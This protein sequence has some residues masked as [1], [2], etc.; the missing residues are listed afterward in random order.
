MGVPSPSKGALRAIVLNDF[1]FSVEVAAQDHS[2]DVLWNASARLR[3]LSPLQGLVQ[4]SFPPP[5][6][7]F[8][9]LSRLSKCVIPR[10]LYLRVVN[11]HS[12]TIFLYAR[13]GRTRIFM[14]DIYRRGWFLSGTHSTSEIHGERGLLLA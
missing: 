12:I 10:L 3:W 4:R 11:I 9:R 2:A 7:R 13:E 14:N 1:T 8:L 5:F 6:W